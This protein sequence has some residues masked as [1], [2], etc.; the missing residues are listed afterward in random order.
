MGDH[1][2]K[3]NFLDFVFVICVSF[4]LGN[5]RIWTFTNFPLTALSEGKKFC[6]RTS[7]LWTADGCEYYYCH[8]QL[9]SL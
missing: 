2:N 4:L 6:R 1:Y 8:E 9:C 5:G 3:I 7:K